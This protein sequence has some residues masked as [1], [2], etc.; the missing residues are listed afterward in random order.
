MFFSNRD[1][2]VIFTMDLSGS[3][4]FSNREENKKIFLCFYD[5][6]II[7][8]VAFQPNERLVYNLYYNC[9]LI[10]IPTGEVIFTIKD[11]KTYYEI[12][13]TGKTYRACENNFKVN[14]YFGSKV[15][16]KSLFPSNIVRIV[17]EGNYK[18][19]NSISFD[20]SRNTALSFQ[21]KSKNKTKIQLHHLDQ[22]MQDKV[23][24]F[25]IMRNISTDVLKK[26]DHSG[27]KMFFDIEMFPINVSFIDKKKKNLKSLG[28][29]YTL[30]FVPDVVE[31]NVFKKGDH[32]TLWVCDD[33]NHFPLMIEYPVSFGSIKAVLLSQTRL[34]HPL[35]AII[36]N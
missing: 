23:S 13:A 10:W 18:L 1:I 27:V 15:D 21:G 28:I 11:S 34:K 30:K 5:A 20:Q 32:M 22:C 7:S 8:N 12:K 31:G 24:N 29:F 33:K 19:Y 25:N 36:D 26:G 17:E 4:A 2:S 35:D 9:K 16:K 14:D 3:M 6:C